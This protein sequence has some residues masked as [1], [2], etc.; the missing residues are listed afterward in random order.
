MGLFSTFLLG[1]QF[2]GGYERLRHFDVLRRR[3]CHEPVETD[4]QQIGDVHQLVER[5]VGLAVLGQRHEGGR[6]A[7]ALGEL[8]FGVAVGLARRFDTRADPEPSTARPPSS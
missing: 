2:R 3:T 6:D 8:D 5:N 1:G 7:D 4:H